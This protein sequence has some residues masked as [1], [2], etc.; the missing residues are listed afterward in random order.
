[1]IKENYIPKEEKHFQNPENS[2]N[3]GN[4]Q[5][6]PFDLKILL[7]FESNYYNGDE[8]MFS[9]TEKADIKSKNKS[10]N[11]SENTAHT[12][13]IINDDCNDSK[14]LLISEKTKEVNILNK[15]PFI[16]NISDNSIINLLELYKEKVNYLLETSYQT[17]EIFMLIKEME[18]L[19]D[20]L[21]QK[22]NSINL[23]NLSNYLSK[24]SFLQ[25]QKQSLENKLCHVKNPIEIK[26]YDK[27]ESKFGKYWS[28]YIFII[29]YIRLYCRNKIIKNIFKIIYS[30]K[31]KIP[32]YLQNKE[33]NKCKFYN[34]GVRRVIFICAHS[35]D[36]FI[37]N[38]ILKKYNIKIQKLNIN[39]Q[40]KLDFKNYRN[41]FN[42]SI[43]DIYSD[44]FPKKKGKKYK[45]E[46][47]NYINIS[48]IKNAIEKENINKNGKI[49]ILDF[50]FNEIKFKKIL[51]LFLYDCKDI[52]IS[53]TIYEKDKV[54]NL[55]RFKTF[56]DFLNDT[57][58]KDSKEEIKERLLKIMDEENKEIKTRKPKKK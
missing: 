47:K 4:N 10:N 33:E 37:S 16:S 43:I 1:M 8:M 41:F 49:K 31:K 17:K 25:E 6:N 22:C 20:I 52:N 2:E 27:I 19:I 39:K 21:Y 32:K 40:L 44:S 46:E 15:K 11:R 14:K 3:E 12:S 42:K 54:F 29:E 7:P 35:F 57:F 36:N 28:N 48:L 34:E 5:N 38:Y 51:K 58:D 50:L 13:E 24:I 18:I 30:Y 55:E 9:P 26:D 23:K 56:K 53:I 45:N